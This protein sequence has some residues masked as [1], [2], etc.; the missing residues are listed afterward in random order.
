M[1]K[2]QEGELWKELPFDKGACQKRYAV[3]NYGRL[4]S[5]INGIEVDG[6]QLKTHNL[7]GYSM[8]TSRCIRGAHAG[9]MHKLVAQFFIE[10][11]SEEQ[12]YVIHKDFN[13]SNN[14][15]DNLK[16]ATK[17]E[18]FKH[19]EKNPNVIIARRK[20]IGK[21]MYQGHKLNET[22]VKRLKKK[23]MDPNRK[24]RLKLIAKQFGIS[25]MQLYRIKSG[26]NW[27]HVDPDQ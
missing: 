25:E 16:W 17:E 3:S 4:V 19:Y 24:T 20:Q 2:T 6:R 5:F 12:K 21:R 22:Q 1:V 15:V 23:I 8:I 9:Y 27:G 13:K 11:A 26:E 10:K 7:K 18:M 14:C